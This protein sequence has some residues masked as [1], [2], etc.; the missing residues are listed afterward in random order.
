M[1][2]FATL[3]IVAAAKS[4]D[5][6]SVILNGS[7][8]WLSGE[9]T[10]KAVVAERQEEMMTRLKGRTFKRIGRILAKN[11]SG[12]AHIP[13]SRYYYLAK[14]AYV[15]GKWNSKVIPGGISLS[16]DVDS[17]KVAYL[18]SYR[19]TS[20]GGSSEYAVVLISQTRLN[21]V[22]PVCGAAE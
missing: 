8:R 4:A 11:A 17:R 12:D 14:G 18:S 21:K 20:E 15:G 22:V 16:A 9:Y 6:T 10:A 7:H 19:L 1:M 3:A 2:I 5:C 13:S